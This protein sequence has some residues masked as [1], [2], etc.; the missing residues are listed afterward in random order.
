M[1][2][3]RILVIG[4]CGQLGHEL[5]VALKNKYGEKAIIA[6]DRLEY[7][8]ANIK[9]VKYVKLDVMDKAYLQLVIVEERITQIYLLAAVLSASGEKDPGMAWQVNMNGLLNVLDLSVSYQVEKVFWP[10]SI[11]VFGPESPKEDCG[12][13]AFTIPTTVYGISKLSGEYWC[14]YYFEKFGLDVRSLRYP[15]LI[16]YKTLPGG[17]TTDYAV[18]IFYKAKAGEKYTCFLKSDT[19]LPMMFMDDA[20]KATLD[21]METQKENISIRTSYNLAAVSFT[22][23]ELATAIRKVEPN[24]EISY[25]PDFRQEI[26]DGWPASI[27]DNV[28]REDWGWLPRFGTDEIVNVM[29]ENVKVEKTS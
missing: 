14:R 3:E 28:A 5:T 12:Q 24:F 4:A 27:N 6:C 9:D 29:M 2:E 1:K 15:G 20:V 7:A 16:S 26:A 10:S 11:A 22:P 21:L 17:G 25:E 19:A 23:S 18:D 8:K 13:N